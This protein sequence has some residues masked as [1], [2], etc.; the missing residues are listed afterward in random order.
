[1]TPTP[2]TAEKKAVGELLLL[3]YYTTQNKVPNPDISWRTSDH[4]SSNVC[5][6][7]ALCTHWPHGHRHEQ[8][9]G[10]LYRNYSLDVRNIFAG[11][12]TQQHGD[13]L[14]SHLT[15]TTR[16]SNIPGSMC[17]VACS[18]LDAL[19]LEHGLCVPSALLEKACG[20]Y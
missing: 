7:C 18:L 1:M 20:S 13:A 17:Q 12:R 19:H 2:S 3:S 8:S 4:G 10:P 5:K 6:K 15:S 11:S 16:H 9:W 14:T